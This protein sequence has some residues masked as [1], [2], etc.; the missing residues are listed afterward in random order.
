MPKAANM[1]KLTWNKELAILAQRWADQCSFEHDT[2]EARK[3]DNFTSV[4]Q[5][6]YET[7]SSKDK[8]GPPSKKGVKK[9]Y[10]EISM[11]TNGGEDFQFKH[12][13]GH[14]T[15]LVWAETFEVRIRKIYLG[16]FD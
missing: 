10:D 11:Y 15:Q 9:W 5:N 14:F 13:T 3:N 6:I 2:K 8:P 12:E 4:G 1:R 16:C 7:S